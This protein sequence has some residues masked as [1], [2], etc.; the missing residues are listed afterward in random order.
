M[1]DPK[2]ESHSLRTIL[3]SLKRALGLV[4]MAD[5]K[6]TFAMAALTLISGLLPVAQAWIA[7]LI[8]DSVISSTA[9]HVEAKAALIAILPYLY[10]EFGLILTGALVSQFRRLLDEILDHKIGFLINS[11]I[12]RKALHLELHYFENAEFY[13]KMQNARKQSE[14][15]AM[16]IVNA[17]FQLLTGARHSAYFLDIANRFQ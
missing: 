17:I 1:S 4:W 6:S 5:A 13:D 2:K 3:H 15:R 12:I 9:A 7:K 11:K 10:I 14:Y 8:V 16:A